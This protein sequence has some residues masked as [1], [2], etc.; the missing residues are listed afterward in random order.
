MLLGLES[1]WIFRTVVRYIWRTVVRQVCFGWRMRGMFSV[2]CVRSF[3]SIWAAA[4]S[5]VV[6]SRV[7]FSSRLLFRRGFVFGSSAEAMQDGPSRP[8]FSWRVRLD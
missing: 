3:L 8:I 6:P 1:V 2:P 5:A 7:Y 4:K